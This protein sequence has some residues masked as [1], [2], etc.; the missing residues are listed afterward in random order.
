MVQRQ[1]EG[2]LTRLLGMPGWYVAG[3]DLRRCKGRSD[4]LEREE[5]V[6]T[7]GKCGHVYPGALL[8]PGQ[9][10]GLEAMQPVLDRAGGVAQQPGDGRGTQ[11]LGDQQRPVDAMVIRRFVR[12]MDFRLK[13][14]Q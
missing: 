3:T 2:Y 14:E 5:A 10:S 8:Q 11:P 6:Y 7:C 12:P 1:R 13:D 4:F 9:P